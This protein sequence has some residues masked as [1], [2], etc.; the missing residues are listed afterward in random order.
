MSFPNHSSQLNESDVTGATIR[1]NSIGNALRTSMELSNNTD[2]YSDHS[3]I[4]DVTN[5]SL[6]QIS[7]LLRNICIPFIATVGLIGNSLSL[8]VFTSRKLKHTSSSNF[9]ASLAVVDNIFLANLLLTWIDGEF[10]NIMRNIMACESI[11]FV[12]YVTGFLSVWFIVGFTTE[13][14]MAICFPFRWQLVF[15]TFREKMIVLI[16]ILTAVL[17]YNHSFWTIRNL[18]QGPRYTCIAKREMLDF[19]HAITW[20]DTIV[21]MVVPFILIVFM[22]VRVLMAAATCHR[23]K[24]ALCCPQAQISQGFV[25]TYILPRNGLR[26][27]S[28]IR[29]TRTLIL[30]SSTFLVLNLPSHVL[31]L[32]NLIFTTVLPDTHFEVSV[33]LYFVQEIANFLYY[34]TFSCNFIL[35]AMFG[36]HFQKNLKA[37]LSCSSTT[38]RESREMAQ[39]LS[40]FRNRTTTTTSSFQKESVCASA[41]GH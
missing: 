33:E 31:R 36:R 27:R 14:F 18:K 5:A 15:S 11:M 28:Q 23:N 21:T 3:N 39:R 30:V 34:S 25:T 8:I 19:L 29:V 35:Y 4:E 6:M 2:L 1:L 37:I 38:N 7:T 41:H 24:Q 17:L 20:L 16:L 26:Y 10:Y 9:L 40:S 13:R 12:T 22:N 32:H